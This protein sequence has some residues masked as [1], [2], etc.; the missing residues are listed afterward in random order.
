MVGD[1]VIGGGAVSQPGQGMGHPGRNGWVGWGM[2]SR[3][4]PREGLGLVGSS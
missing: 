4:W 2:G 1:G 3:S